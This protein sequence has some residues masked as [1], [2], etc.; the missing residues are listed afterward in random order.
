MLALELLAV[1]GV[2]GIEAV[3]GHLLDQPMRHPAARIGVLGI[4]RVGVAGVVGIAV[5]GGGAL[6]AALASAR[7]SLQQLG[8][9]FEIVAA[10][11]D[12]RFDLGGELGLF[13]LAALREGGLERVLFGA[14]CVELGFQFFGAE[15]V[16][17]VH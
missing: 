17:F 10:F 15:M 7:A 4:V 1:I 11:A 9:L 12:Q 8:N 3:G 16:H 5:I 14:E 13:R 2:R 6:A